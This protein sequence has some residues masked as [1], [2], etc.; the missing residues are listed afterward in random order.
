MSIK[1]VESFLINN[2]INKL[3]SFFAKYNIME[4]A[5]FRN[6]GPS[7]SVVPNYKFSHIVYYKNYFLFF[8]S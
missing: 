5:I 4:G 7:S 2:N 6:A 8:Q 1:Q 3:G